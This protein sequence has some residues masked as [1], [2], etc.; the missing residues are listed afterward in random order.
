MAFLGIHSEWNQMVRV[1]EGDKIERFKLKVFS[2][3]TL[4]LIRLQSHSVRREGAKISQSIPDSGIDFKLATAPYFLENFF[5][6]D[7]EPVKS[8]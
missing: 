1:E 3:E 7:F 2:E 4:S 6:E 8:L 5:R